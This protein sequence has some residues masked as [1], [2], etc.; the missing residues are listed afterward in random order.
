MAL[1]KHP[2]PQLQE[3]PLSSSPAKGDSATVA[4]TPSCDSLRIV[5]IHDWLVS[6][7]GGEKVLDLLCSRFPGAPLYTLLHIPGSV[8]STIEN[9]EIKTSLLQA[10]PFSRTKYRQ[11]LPFFPLFAEL[12]KV[13]DYDVV[14]SS[15]HAVAKG[16][17]R[18]DKDSRP[19]HICYIHTPMRYIW[20]RFD[21]YFGPDKVG[22]LA[23]NCVFKP[24]AKALQAYDRRTVDRVD[25]FIAN[26]RFVADRVK[27]HYGR[28]AEIVAP[29]VA[30][31]RFLERRRSPEPWYLV[32]SALAPYKR[33]D[34]AIAACAAM[35]R[36]L[37]IIGS[38]PEEK[39]LRTLA[40]DLNAKVE[41]L[42]F[43]GDSQLGEYYSRAKGLLFPGVEDFGI[44]PVE[45]IAAGCPVVAFAEG[46][47]LDS[48]TANTA[49][50]YST[51]TAD[52]LRQ[53]MTRFE[54]RHFSEKELRTRAAGFAPE[55]FL[56]RFDE[57]LARSLDHWRDRLPAYNRRRA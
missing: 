30:V 9:R 5:L 31:E 23:S 1:T 6:M 44:V 40:R 45:A 36:E 42:G 13:S 22:R 16:M 20:D 21:D 51:A 11:Y 19:L 28:E 29:P 46:G 35:G 10:L 48:M 32:V 54:G 24:V 7:R 33:V 52:G 41:F 55:C 26:S 34:Q 37:K 3:R 49:E 27:R 57:I 47:I 50:L 25:V 53:A 8:S 38:G 15:S 4:A 14:I 43:V 2:V 17:V 12:S 39:Q 18:R 56:C